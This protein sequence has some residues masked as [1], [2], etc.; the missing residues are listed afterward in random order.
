MIDDTL[1]DQIYFLK[2]FTQKS[3]TFFDVLLY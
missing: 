2:L 1:F 3:D